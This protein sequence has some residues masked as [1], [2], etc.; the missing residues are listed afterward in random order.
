MADLHHNPHKVKAMAAR[1]KKNTKD[2]SG[3]VIDEYEQIFNSVYFKFCREKEITDQRKQFVL[4][5]AQFLIKLINMR[6][7]GSKL[8]MNRKANEWI[9]DNIDSLY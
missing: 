1:M 4:F 7:S 3:R 6:Y 5:K 8:C 2:K 9:E